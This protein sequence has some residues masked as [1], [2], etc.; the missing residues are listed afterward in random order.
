VVDIS[1]IQNIRIESAVLS[2]T[3]TEAIFIAGAIS[4]ITIN[5]T[6]IVSGGTYSVGVSST[7]GIISIN[8]MDVNGVGGIIVSG[9]SS[10]INFRTANITAS[11]LRGVYLQAGTA[12][13]FVTVRSISATSD[14]CVRCTTGTLDLSADILTSSTTET[15]NINGATAILQLGVDQLLSGATSRTINASNGTLKVEINTLKGL[16]ISGASLVYLNATEMDQVSATIPAFNISSTASGKIYI[17]SNLIA[18]N[19]PC[20]INGTAALLVN[21]A[22][23]STTATTGAYTISGGGNIYINGE[24][25][26]STGPGIVVSGATNIYLNFES[27]T[28]TNSF[29]ISGGTNTYIDCK[30]TSSSGVGYSITGGTM[31]D[32]F[33]LDNT[34]TGIALSVSGTPTSTITYGILNTVGNFP[35]NLA[36]DSIYT[37]ILRNCYFKNPSAVSGSHAVNIAN[38]ASVP[39]IITY[40]GVFFT[41][42]VDGATHALNAVTTNYTQ[43]RIYQAALG[44]RNNANVAIIVGTYTSDAQV[45]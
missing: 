14:N 26:V 18:T 23:M 29:A 34:A 5:A 38:G 2:S 30:S 10:E 1:N 3:N 42:A 19:S 7:G 15:V 27:V 25:V 20:T 28:A 16:Q 45:I 41:T 24:S 11:L 13:L 22:A 17:T 31:I 4:H 6:Q 37:I 36:R 12:S 8:A 21:I 35:V 39:L 9:G 43:L 32:M 44:N 40:N 33:G